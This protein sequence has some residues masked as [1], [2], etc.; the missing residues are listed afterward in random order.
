MISFAGYRVSDSILSDSTI[1][2]FVFEGNGAVFHD[3][4][5]DG[6]VADGS[7]MTCDVD[8]V[9]AVEMYCIDSGQLFLTLFIVAGIFAILPMLS[10]GAEK[11]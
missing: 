7:E 2:D 8:S 4:I 9:L 3:G 6:V 5:I 10:H 1:V 11:P